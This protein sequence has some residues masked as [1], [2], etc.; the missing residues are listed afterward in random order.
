[1]Y[2]R[3]CAAASIG[4]GD[5]GQNVKVSDLKVRLAQ[6]DFGGKYLNVQGAVPLVPSMTLNSP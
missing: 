4:V 3:N 6:V 1:M 2:T 5:V